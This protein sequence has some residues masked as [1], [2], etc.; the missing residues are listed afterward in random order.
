[1]KALTNQTN[2]ERAAAVPDNKVKLREAHNKMEN[3]HY[4]KLNVFVDTV[5][6]HEAFVILKVSTIIHF[7]SF[8]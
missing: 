6:P 5:I 3:G 4:L 1:M 8:H 7:I 2:L